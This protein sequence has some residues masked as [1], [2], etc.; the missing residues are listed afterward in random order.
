[1][2]VSIAAAA[3]A[4]KDKKEAAI[5]ADRVEKAV[6]ELKEKVDKISDQLR[7]IQPNNNNNNTTNSSSNESAAGKESE[8]K[9]DGAKPQQK[10]EDVIYVKKASEF[11]FYS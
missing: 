2:G 9:S 5:E 4:N 10:T 3:A 11:W 8:K 6:S 1:M 7:A